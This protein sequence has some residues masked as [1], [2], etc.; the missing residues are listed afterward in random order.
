VSH[1]VVGR[2]IS[3]FITILGTSFLVFSAVRFLPGS[4]VDIIASTSTVGGPEA[5]QHVE[6]ELGLDESLPVGYVHWL[7][8]ITHGDFGKSLIN[9]QPI[10]DYI[11][12]G[13][14]VTLELGLMSLFFGVVLGVPIGVISAVKQD[15]W[16][17]FGLRGIAIV[18]LAIPGFLIATIVIVVASRAWNWNPPITYIRF[19]QDPV[20][21][22]GQFVL[23]AII[24]GFS[25]AAA[26]MRFT[27][28]AMLEV[29]RQDY[30]RT[31]RAKG[32]ADRTV[33]MRHAFRNALV[34]IISVI[35]I[36][37]AL[38]VGGTV[39]FEQIFQ[40]PGV[41]RFLLSEVNTRDYPGVQ[42]ISLI[43]AVTVV[44]VNL[45]TDL[46]YTFVDPRVRY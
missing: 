13:I 29:Y 30:V 35:G 11:K 43:F 15:S 37:L 34:P 27:R 45:A 32:L 5:R 22:L 4:A 25:S 33:V 42:A 10:S 44:M 19:T 21:N 8:N 18:L 16:L 7:G 31:V 46:A 40:L 23:P 3:A 1:Y 14:P 12:E 9:G 6:H 17:D 24:L 36:F 2:L 39:I 26:L 41:G 38:I 28:T 20:H